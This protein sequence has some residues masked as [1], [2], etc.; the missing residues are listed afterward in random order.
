MAKQKKYNAKQQIAESFGIVTGSQRAS[1][2]GPQSVFPT[3]YASDTIQ[4]TPQALMRS[5]N[6]LAM[7]PGAAGSS[8]INDALADT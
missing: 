7:L 3:I 5:I 4:S 2:R 1:T 8:T 6:P